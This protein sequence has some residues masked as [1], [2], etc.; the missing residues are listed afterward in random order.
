[1]LI[2]YIYMYTKSQVAFMWIII[3]ASQIPYVTFGEIY[4]G[5]QSNTGGE[6]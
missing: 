2:A 5:E 1:M 3:G 6:C 4:T